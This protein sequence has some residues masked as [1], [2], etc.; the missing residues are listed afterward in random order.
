M[1]HDI[2]EAFASLVQKAQKS[3]LDLTLQPNNRSLK[4]DL[5]K[6]LSKCF[7]ALKPLQILF[8]YKLGKTLEQENMTETKKRCCRIGHQDSICVHLAFLYDAACQIESAAKIQNVILN[9]F[10]ALLTHGLLVNIQ[11]NAENEDDNVQQI[12][13]LIQ[14][15]SS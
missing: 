12:M 15:I 6:N 7:A 13:N 8:G 11:S 2:L 5:E 14:Q 9:I 10:S 3:L 4:D 1:L